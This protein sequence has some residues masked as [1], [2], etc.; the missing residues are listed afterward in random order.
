MPSFHGWQKKDRNHSI[1]CNNPLWPLNLCPKILRLRDP[2]TLLL[3]N[4]LF[5][6]VPQHPLLLGHGCT[7]CLPIYHFRVVWFL[8]GSS[9]KA[10]SWQ[11]GLDI[12][13]S[14]FN[15]NPEFRSGL[16][17]P[18]SFFFQRQAMSPLFMLGF[19]EMGGFE[20]PGHIADCYISE[21]VYSS[22]V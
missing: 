13:I 8:P 15:L 7:L 2:G 1:P 22:L 11:H 19:G 12:S 9:L 21:G 4:Y 10:T 17:S 6:M 3:H 5:H 14:S 18:A 20:I 16:T